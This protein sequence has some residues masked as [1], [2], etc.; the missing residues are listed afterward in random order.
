MI[1]VFSKNYYQ[2]IVPILKLQD[3]PFYQKLK[4]TSLKFSDA[5]RSGGD[6]CSVLANVEMKQSEVGWVSGGCLI[7]LFFFS[8]PVITD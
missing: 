4:F 7:M 2:E 6:I 8:F 5:Q 1:C 3:T